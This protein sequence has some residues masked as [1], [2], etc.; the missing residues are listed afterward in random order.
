MHRMRKRV[1]KTNKTKYYSL[2]AISILYYVV[3][4]IAACTT[5]AGTIMQLVGV[6]RTCVCKA[7]LFYGLPLWRSGWVTA[8]VKLSMDNQL[9]KI[10]S[11]KTILDSLRV[12]D[13]ITG[14]F[15]ILFQAPR[16]EPRQRQGTTT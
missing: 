15:K 10:A 16:W 7:G 6:Y 4:S 1:Q 11:L 14:R 2:W 5:I 13:N 3:G 12:T 9:I 8:Q